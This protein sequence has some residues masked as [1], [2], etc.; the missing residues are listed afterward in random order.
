MTQLDLSVKIIGD[1]N[2]CG[3]AT[4]P[5]QGM[6]STSQLGVQSFSSQP[7][8]P[9]VSTIQT[10]VGCNKVTVYQHKLVCF[11]ENVFKLGSHVGV[12]K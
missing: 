8:K 12:T 6:S 3:G 1:I 4:P 5:V 2:L 10:S 9:T 7:A 11:V